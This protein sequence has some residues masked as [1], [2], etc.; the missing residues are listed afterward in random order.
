MT[1]TADPAEQPRLAE[2]LDEQTLRATFPD[3]PADIS[4]PRDVGSMFGA[5]LRELRRTHGTTAY[6][7]VGVTAFVVLVLVLIGHAL[8]GIIVLALLVAVLAGIGFWQHGVAADAFFDRY[9]T[10]RGL[11]HSENSHV[12]AHVPL[13][14]RGDERKFPRVLAGRIAGQDARLAHYTYTEISTDSDGNRSRTDYE[15]TVLAFEL[16]PQVAARYRGVSLAPRSLS[17]GAL[18]DWV[19]DDRKVELESAEFAKRYNLRAHDSQDDVALWELFSTTFVHRLATELQVYWEQRGADL[20]FWQK[21]HESE[22]ADLDR[23]CLEAW[24]VLQ[25]YL[26]EWQ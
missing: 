21:G 24:H 16:P 15:F 1:E 10:A 26:E 6:V 12:S 23:F 22:A 17:F 7:G 3:A 2:T 4:V 20:V 14:R 25:R 18:Q 5:R 8:A 9:A 13:L 11:R 19:Q